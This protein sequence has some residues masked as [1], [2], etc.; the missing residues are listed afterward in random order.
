MLQTAENVARR[1]GISRE[2][3]DIYGVQSQQRAAAAQ[4]AGRFKAEIAPVW[5]RMKVVDKATWARS[6]AALTTWPPKVARCVMF[7]D[8]RH[9]L[10]RGVRAVDA[11]TTS[12]M[13]C[14]I[15]L[16]LH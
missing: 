3:Q 10:Q 2:A 16:K 12:C 4:S 13:S 11:I 1:Y 15:W 9:D 6:S 8:P 14:P 7:K 5:T